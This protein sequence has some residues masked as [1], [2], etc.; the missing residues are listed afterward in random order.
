MAKVADISTKLSLNNRDFK[1]G[2]QSTSKSLGKFHAAF[3]NAA[4][5]IAKAG[6]AALAAVGVVMVAIVKKTA[7]KIDKLSKEAR[8][9]DITTEMLAGI[10]HAAKLSGLDQDKLGKAL[11]KM[12]KAVSEANEGL[13][14]Q[15]KAFEGLGISIKDLRKMDAGEQFLAIADGLQQVGN[16]S[17][18]VRIA[19]DIFGRTGGDMLITMEQGAEGI[20]KAI[21]EAKRLGIT[22]SEEQGAMVEEANDSMTK[23]ASIGEGAFNQLTI[24]VAPFISL[25]SDAMTEAALEGESMTDRVSAGIEKIVKIIGVLGNAVNLVKG[26]IQFAFGGI[27]LV[28]FGTLKGI[29]ESLIWI[30]GKLDSALRAASK[31]PFA[32]KLGIPAGINPALTH[33]ETM[34]RMRTAAST[35]YI[36]QGMSDAR[37]NIAAGKKS[38]AA[39]IDLDF[40][41]KLLADYHETLRKAAI[42]AGEIKKE[43]EARRA[44]RDANAAVEDAIAEATA[45]AA[46]AAKAT[47]KAD[48][49]AA[50]AAAKAAKAAAKAAAKDAKAK[51]APAKEI[52]KDVVK[53]VDDII[54][55]V[56]PLVKKIRFMKFEADAGPN[57]LGKVAKAGGFSVVIP[58]RRMDKI[59]AAFEPPPDWEPGGQWDPRAPWNDPHGKWGDIFDAAND[60]ERKKADMQKDKA[61][62][63][64][65]QRDKTLIAILA[66]VQQ[67]RDSKFVAFAS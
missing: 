35:E 43:H 24:G 53:V 38:L 1:K 6:V 4:G 33:E 50:K 14:T 25:W 61:A 49:A 51:A 29:N 44:L 55:V 60:P 23:L 5:K 13:S 12:T 18:K 56:Q 47:A 54:D 26:T 41:K 40:S 58:P 19:M 63:A 37:G 7:E 34:D 21:E 52:I 65:V 10:G 66:A 31:L 32:E 57:L 11:V 45:K 3:K 64:E 2:L 39:A 67:I 27:Q 46:K 16:H 9:L 15:K 17:D 20:R 30:F 36:A 42:R 22:F 8:K 48:K 28:I 59:A 62:A